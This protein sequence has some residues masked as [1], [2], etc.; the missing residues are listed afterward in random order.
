MRRNIGFS[1]LFLYVLTFIQVDMNA[2]SE[3][4]RINNSYTSFSI[5]EKDLLPESI[6]YDSANGDFYMGSTRKGKIIK[7]SKN[8]AISDFIHPKQDGLWMVVGLKSILKEESYG[9]VVR[10]ETILKDTI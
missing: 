3:K 10:E 2:Q 7:V 8:G 5:P 9:H 6:A 1:V 4:T